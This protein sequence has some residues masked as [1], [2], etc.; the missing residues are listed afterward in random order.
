MQVLS[1]SITE[2]DGKSTASVLLSNMNEVQRACQRTGHYVAGKAVYVVYGTWLI[3]QNTNT[4]RQSYSRSSAVKTA[5]RSCIPVAK[6]NKL[7]SRCQD[8]SGK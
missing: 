7:G 3:F 5:G 8:K 4:S 6:A 2:E 1:V